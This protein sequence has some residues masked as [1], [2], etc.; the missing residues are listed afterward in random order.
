MSVLYKGLCSLYTCVK[1]FLELG[2]HIWERCDTARALLQRGCP[3]D[4][5][6]DPRGSTVLLKNQ[7]ITFNPKEQRR[8]RQQGQVTQL[9]PQT[10]LL[11]LRPGWWKNMYKQPFLL[12][13]FF[14]IILIIISSFIFRYLSHRAHRG[15]PSELQ[16][17]FTVI[18][19]KFSSRP[20]RSDWR[21]FL[22]FMQFWQRH[23]NKKVLI[24]NRSGWK[25][26]ATTQSSQTGCEWYQNK[27]D[28]HG[29]L[30]HG[31]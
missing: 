20:Q 27:N 9:Q 14:I 3:S 10:V 7:R 23:R 4:R 29:N 12:R 18:I 26:G 15:V 30:W 1:S 13:F 16:S 6:E 17:H 8:Q 28:T 22:E 2:Q 19:V 24:G 21:S 5:L 11:N 31:F 25:H